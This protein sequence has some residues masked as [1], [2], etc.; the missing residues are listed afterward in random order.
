M[1]PL[2]NEDRRRSRIATYFRHLAD[3]GK[4]SADEHSAE[5]SKKQLENSLAAV[6][7]SMVEISK[8][9]DDIENTLSLYNSTM[10]SI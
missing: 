10:S 2:K 4:A 8:V 9:H 3:M 7:R 6:R 1:I 5:E